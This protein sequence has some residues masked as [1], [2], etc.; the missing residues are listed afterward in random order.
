M[1]LVLEV[2]AAGWRAHL[3]SYLEVEPRVVPVIKGNGYGFGRGELLREAAA[4]GVDTV[5]VGTYAEAAQALELTTIETVLVLEP[6]RPEPD[7]GRP[8]AAS[9]RLLHTVSRVPDLR[10]LTQHS[11]AGR[12]VRVAIELLTSMR[13]HGVDGADLPALSAQLRTA[14]GLGV[15]ASAFHLPIDRPRGADPVEEVR[16]SIARLTDAGIRLGT[17]YTS[18]LTREEQSQLASAR[19]DVRCRPRVGTALWLG[20]GS[21]VRAR[22]R[23]VDVHPV[24]RG[25]RSGYRQRRLPADG[26]L[27]VVSGGTAHGIGL[28]AAVAPRGL[29]RARVLAAAGLDA[30]GLR[31]SPFRW[32]GSQRWYAEPPHMQVS[33]LF[34]PA[35]VI[36]P[37]VGDWLDVDCRKTTTTFDEVRLS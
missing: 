31:L 7:A 17:A 37:A 26:S 16:G 4:L 9:Q 29:A 30:L 32:L 24:R 34:L 12:P 8:P 22:A 21:M 19:A 13:R 28:D 35:T 3:R 11:A 15:E 5:A 1:T 10:A 2:D 14:H 23:V 25:D 6:W 36:P 18:H 27:V 33:T 20:T